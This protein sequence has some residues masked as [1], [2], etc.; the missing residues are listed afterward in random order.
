VASPSALPLNTPGSGPSFQAVFEEGSG[1]AFRRRNVA[2]SGFS[3][4]SVPSQNVPG[5]SYNTETGFFSTALPA[6]NAISL[7]GSADSGTRLR[8]SFENLPKNVVIWVSIRD[9]A[10]GTR[11]YDP[12]N[13][14]ALLTAATPNGDGPFTPPVPYVPGWEAV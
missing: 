6:T 13:P 14:T 11:N 12:A 4:G 10:T 2:T 7:T 3:P 8:L 5:L 9:I 1:G